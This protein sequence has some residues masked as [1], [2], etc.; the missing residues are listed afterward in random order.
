MSITS[1]LRPLFEPRQRQ[2]ERYATDAERLQTGVMRRLLSGATS[3]EWGVAHGFAGIRSYEDFAASSPLNSYDDLKPFIVRMMHGEKDVLWRGRVSHFAKSS[4]TT[5]DRSKFLP[6]SSD[7][8]RDTHY[9]GGQDCV[10]AYLKNNPSSRIF[11][12]RALILG[13]SRSEADSTPE[14]MVGDLSAILIQNI[15][16]LV[17]LIRVPAKQTALLPDFEVKRDRIAREAMK[18]N[19]T[20]LSGVPSWMLSVMNRV[21]ELSGAANLLEVWPH[22]EMFFHGGVAFTPY[23]EQA[24]SLRGDALYGDLQRLRGLL[25]RADRPGRRRHV[26]DGGLR[27]LLRVRAHGGAGEGVARG[28][29][30]LGGGTE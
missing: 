2:L 11:D 14:S 15:N 16:P 20:N 8:L 5:S 3:T 17:N 21:L 19:V 4:G 1:L 22:L 29:A 10:A 26:A 30:S 7:A 12:G 13:G 6:V 18:K 24:D 28:V 27:H 9:R 25:R 23:R